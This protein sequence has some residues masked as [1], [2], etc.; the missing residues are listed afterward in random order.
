MFDNAKIKQNE[1]VT[2]NCWIEGDL[3]Y[4]KKVK[5]L[6]ANIPVG[7]FYKTGSKFIF[8]TFPTY[9]QL[10]ILVVIFC[11]SLSTTSYGS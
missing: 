8:H 5:T 1:I 4:M 9:I 10:D 7:F 6:T 3:D 11:H 2:F